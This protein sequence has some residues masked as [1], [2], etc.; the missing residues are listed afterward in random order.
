[1]K[2]N[3]LSFDLEISVISVFYTEKLTESMS[4]LY[5]RVSLY[6]IMAILYGNPVIKSFRGRKKSDQSAKITIL[7]NY[8]SLIYHQTTTDVSWLCFIWYFIQFCWSSE[9]PC[10]I[11]YHLYKLWFLCK[12]SN[13][14]DVKLKGIFFRCIM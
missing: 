8:N 14:P 2:I 4:L 9:I 10:R 1:M 3:L 5:T 12:S 6:C 7:Q 11:F 13:F